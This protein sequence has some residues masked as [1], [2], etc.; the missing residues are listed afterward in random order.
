MA[1]HIVDEPHDQAHDGSDDKQVGDTREIRGFKQGAG[2][3]VDKILA[4]AAQ[5]HVLG[6]NLYNAVNDQLHAQGADECGHAQE[7][8]HHT[9]DQTE[10]TADRHADQQYQNHRE[11]RQ[12]GPETARKVGVLKQGACDTGA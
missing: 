4:E 2:T 9:V 3:D 12:V 1:G 6:V 7:G 11:V 10:D 8:N 5:R